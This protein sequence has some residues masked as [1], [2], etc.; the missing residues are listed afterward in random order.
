[1]SND[2]SHVSS[3]VAAGIE[4]AANALEKVYDGVG[5]LDPS[6]LDLQSWQRASARVG[7]LLAEFDAAANQ[8]NSAFGLTSAHAR[9]LTYLRARLGEVVEKEELRGVSAIY[10]WARRVRELRVEHGWPISSNAHRPDLRPGQYV[11]EADEPDE[12]IASDWK[13]AST[14]RK[15]PGGA[16]GRGLELLKALSPRP[17][18]KDQLEYVMKIKSYA[19]RIRELDEEGWKI[20][21]NV[22]NSSLPPGSYVLT[23]LDR[24]PPRV[25]QAIKLRYE[26]LERDKNR[27]RDCGNSPDSDGVTLQVH[28]LLPVSQG[29]NEDADNLI[30]LCSQCHAGRHSVAIG[31][32]RDELL[33]PAS[34]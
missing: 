19:R 28:H 4:R 16:K 22:D 21:S 20:E 15:L 14:I 34:A 2:E 3:A 30:T 27:C 33:D 24:N 25:R 6:V 8:V 10:E 29:G 12:Q 7:V 11:L 13:L 26:I 1:M 5:E 32:T 17:V 23:S 31:D 18:D 9:I